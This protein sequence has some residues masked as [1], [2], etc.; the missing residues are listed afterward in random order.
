MNKEEFRNLVIP[1]TQKEIMYRDYPETRSKYY[2]KKSAKAGIDRTIDENGIWIFPFPD[3]SKNPLRDELIVHG[4]L[5]PNEKL[6]LYGSPIVLSKQTRFSEVPLH[7]HAYIEIAHMYS[8]SCTSVINGETIKLNVG[9]TVIFDSGVVHRVLPTGENDILINIM[10]QQEYFQK[11]FVERFSNAGSVSAYLTGVISEAKDHD[12]FLLFHTKNSSRCKGIM[13]DLY[14]EFLDPLLGTS[15]ALDSYINLLFLE[16]IRCYQNE[17]EESYRTENQKGYITEVLRYIEE[18]VTA[19]TLE[20][21]AER[22]GYHPNYLTRM[23]RK[24]TGKSFKELT[25]ELR[26]A[27]AA[28]MLVTTDESVSRIAE[29]CG[30]TNQNYF[31]KKFAVQFETTPANYRS[32]SREM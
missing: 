13:E 26:L 30:Y 18:N 17:I 32:I 3:A 29:E 9:D 20:E 5:I 31:Y 16:L 7:R 1:L 12:R 11:N 27:K 19:C 25:T 15:Y 21:T 8:G 23:I 24:A 4:N 2:Q 22:F 6:K 14:C 10:M 28:H